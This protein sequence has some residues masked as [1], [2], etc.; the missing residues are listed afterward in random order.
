MITQH[1]LIATVACDVILSAFAIY[2]WRKVKRQEQQ[3]QLLYQKFFNSTSNFSKTKRSILEAKD[4]LQLQ[5]ETAEKAWGDAQAKIEY[6]E[7]QITGLC[8]HS[9]RL[10]LALDELNFKYNHLVG[11]YNDLT[12]KL[13]TDGEMPV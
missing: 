7:K 11:Q 3:K 4:Q 12:A 2:L 1:L 10:Q 6:G 8:Q 9:K 13:P 5:L